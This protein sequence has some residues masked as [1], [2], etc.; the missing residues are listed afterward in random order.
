MQNIDVPGIQGHGQ[1]GAPVTVK[2][3]AM[4][5]AQDMGMPVAVGT[6][7]DIADEIEHYMQRRRGPR[8]HAD[9]DLHA[10]RFEEFVDLLWCPTAVSWF[11]RGGATLRENLSKA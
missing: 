1:G 5:Y 2:E 8:L 11:L 3:A 10:G 4:I 7:A 9:R 6:P